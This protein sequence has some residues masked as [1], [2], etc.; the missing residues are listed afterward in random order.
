MLLQDHVTQLGFNTTTSTRPNGIVRALDLR[1]RKS[2]LKS[3]FC[4]LTTGVFL[5][6]SPNLSKLQLPFCHP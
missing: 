1:V 2:E 5:E 3:M 6:R 4:H